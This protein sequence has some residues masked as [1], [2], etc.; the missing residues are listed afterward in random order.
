MPYIFNLFKEIINIDIGTIVIYTCKK[1]CKGKTMYVEEY[2]YIQRTGESIIDF[3]KGKK[4]NSTTLNTTNDN[5]GNSL[6]NDEIIKNLNKLTVKNNT[7]NEPD[8]EG[9]V[10]VKKKKNTK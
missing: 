4:T 1:S 5:T 2:A 10:E 3:D 8:E 9:W 7:N 6:T